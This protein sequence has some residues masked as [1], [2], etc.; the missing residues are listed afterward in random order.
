LKVVSWVA[1]MV[2]LLA[3]K[4][5]DSLVAQWED[6]MVFLKAVRKEFSKVVLL[7]R[8]VVEGLVS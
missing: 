3:E 8:I 4:M 2:G 5:E 7:E 6:E 1:M